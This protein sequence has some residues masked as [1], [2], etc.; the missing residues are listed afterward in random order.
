[1]QEYEVKTRDNLSLVVKNWNEG[2]VA[3]EQAL[4]IIHGIGEHQGRYEHVADHFV[5]K[6]YDVYTYDQR[7]H[8][9]SGGKR[10]HSPGVDYN[11]DD[12]EDVIT[13]IK[14]SELFLYGHSFGGNVLVNY[15]VRRKNEKLKSAVLSG[16]WMKLKIQPSKID[17]VLA[18]V[19]NSVYPS[20]TQENK[21]DVTTLSNIE[22]V[23]Q[24]YLADPLVHSKISAG[25]FK[26][27]YASGLFAIENAISLNT[28]TLLIHGADD[29]IVDPEGSKEFASRAENAELKIYSDT[30]HELH[31]DNKAE[32]VLEFVSSWLEGK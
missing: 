19:M 9:L 24:K 31:N 20:F 6:G 12:L 23:G 18:T 26:S 8:G 2:D 11:L 27:F 7:G 21:L 22:E 16:A 28:P 5:S 25:L 15:L 1:M 13:S 29:E 10:G 32:E 4:L 14:H 3:S 30:K 17:L